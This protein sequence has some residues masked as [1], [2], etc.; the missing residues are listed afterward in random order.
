MSKS[1]PFPVDHPGTFIAEELDARGWAQADLAYILG[2]DVSQLNRLIKGSTDVTPDSAVALGDAFDMPAEFFLNLQKMYDLHRAKKSDPGVR[3]RASWLSV[4]PVREMIKRGWIEDAEPALLH[5]QMLRFFGKNRVEDIPFVSD[6][7]IIAHAPKKT[8]YEETT[9]I[10]YVWLHRVRKIAEGVTDCPAYSAD[11]LRKALPSIRAHMLDKDDL[12]KIPSILWACGV[13][14][15]FVEALPGSKIDGVCVWLGD[16][17]VIGMTLRLD[18]LDNFC[19]VLRHEIEHILRGDGH[20]ESFTPVDEI[21]A[22][23]DSNS[24]LPACEIIA[25][26]EAGEFCV[27]RDLLNS[28]IERKSPFISERDMLAFAARVKINPCV[29]VGQIQKKT[30]NYAWLR[31]YQTSIREHILDWRLKDG[32]GYPA[33]TGL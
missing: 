18:R 7:E 15:V 8:G 32:W 24:S 26:R 12:I 2:V 9:P 16:Q 20:A 31:K 1:A 17:P 6:A 5:L 13:R 10:Q 4:F 21:G 14:L 25:N 28:F 3:T 19:F 29:V 22:D 30:K 27:P 23:A 11:G 33:P